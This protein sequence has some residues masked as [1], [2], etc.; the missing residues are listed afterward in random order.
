M[1]GRVA[2]NWRVRRRDGRAMTALELGAVMAY[3][4]DH[5][6]VPAGYE[7]HAIDW[8]RPTKRGTWRHGSPGTQA[9]GTDVMRDHF[10]YTLRGRLGVVRVGSVK[11]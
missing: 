6:D 1:S 10:Y 9:E 11:R 2:Y 3:F 7:L 4:E 8:K 5:Q